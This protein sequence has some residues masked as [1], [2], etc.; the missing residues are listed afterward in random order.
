MQLPEPDWVR[1]HF[2][3]ISGCVFMA[4]SRARYPKVFAKRCRKT[5]RWEFLWMQKAEA[6]F[7]SGGSFCL[8]RSA[9]HDGS[10]KVSS[11][12]ENF[13]V[14]LDWWFVPLF[15]GCMSLIMA[16]G[17]FATSRLAQ[18]RRRRDFWLVVDGA[19][20]C[21]SNEHDGNRT[22]EVLHMLQINN[23]MEDDRGHY[24]QVSIKKYTNSRIH[25]S[26]NR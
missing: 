6:Y 25:Q 2:G 15:P 5:V 9:E 18:V 24:S 11:V 23:N 22:Y 13:S 14:F 12:K 1:F 4:L 7:A 8:L 26:I 17:G 3:N 20:N 16:H 21:S 10:A 19:E